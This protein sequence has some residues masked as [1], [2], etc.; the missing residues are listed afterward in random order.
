[1]T[2]TT[3]TTTTTTMTTTTTTTTTTIQDLPELTLLTLF[4]KLTLSELL[5]ID[6]VCKDWGGQLKREAH[7]RRKHLVI[8]KDKTDMLVLERANNCVNSLSP[9]M[10]HHVRKF[11]GDEKKED[12]ENDNRGRWTHNFR[13]LVRLD[14]HALFTANLT[15][16]RVD[17][18][19][20]HLPNLTTLRIVRYT[21]SLEELR[22]IIRLLTA[23]AHQLLEVTLVFFGHYPQPPAAEEVVVERDQHYRFLRQFTLLFGALNR[24]P[25]LRSLKL[26]LEGPFTL[27]GPLRFIDL[28]DLC[29]RLTTFNLYAGTLVDVA[30]LLKQFAERSPCLQE[31]LCID[32]LDLETLLSFGPRVVAAM[33]QAYIEDCLSYEEHFADLGRFGLRYAHLQELTVHLDGLSIWQLAQALAPS[34]KALVSLLIWDLEEEENEDEDEEE[35]EEEEEERRRR[36]GDEGGVE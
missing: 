32:R 20:R 3:T 4:D 5:H 24:L 30:S 31:L 19:I 34:C 28:G 22:Q 13:L 8:V 26:L 1:M 11:E 27:S 35:E 15:P 16:S 2:E 14:R 21:G 18:L 25:A 17:G 10:L 9:K 6:E 23:F 12:K 7:L 33:R 29:A 36:R